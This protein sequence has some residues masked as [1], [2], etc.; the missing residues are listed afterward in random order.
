LLV[1]SC[2]GAETARTTPHVDA[3]VQAVPSSSPPIASESPTAPA[4]IPEAEPIWLTRD[5]WIL[6]STSYVDKTM[7]LPNGMTGTIRLHTPAPG[8][9][10]VIRRRS[11]RHDKTVADVLDFGPPALSK[12]T[13]LSVG[14]GAIERRTVDE[15]TIDAIGVVG[16]SAHA[17]W[18]IPHD[19][20]HLVGNVREPTSTLYIEGVSIGEGKLVV[21]DKGGG[22]RRITVSVVSTP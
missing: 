18:T 10:Q 15:A 21:R 11:E 20:I 22:L 5:D 1:A 6:E 16:E 13:S 3:N 8:A 4:E 9:H 19:V 14:I 7:P 2:G 17:Y 12:T